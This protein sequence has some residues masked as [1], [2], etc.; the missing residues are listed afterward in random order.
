[1]VKKAAHCAYDIHYHLVIVMKYR[2]KLLIRKE[3]VNTLCN[4]MFEIAERYEFEI[5]EFGSDGDHVHVLVSAPPRYAP[6][7]IMQIIKS[8]TGRM[9]F[10]EF[11]ELRKQLWGAE[12]W[13][14]G[15]FVGTIG[16]AAGLEH[17]KKYIK[18]QGD[19]DKNYNLKRY[20]NDTP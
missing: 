2:K 18:K 10:K 6:S 13:S 20:L 11:P 17:M 1:M 9:M 4:L 16:Q 3:Y 8:I 14:D 5:E 15:G 7:K 19:K 12:L